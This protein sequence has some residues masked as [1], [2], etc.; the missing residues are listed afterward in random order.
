MLGP[1]DSLE[2]RIERAYGDLEVL[3]MYPSL[4][5]LPLSV[6]NHTTKHKEKTYA[7]SLKYRVSE[8]CD[9]LTRNLFTPDPYLCSPDSL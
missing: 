2:N 1:P 6:S 7:R 9:D 5:P 8:V 3:R 4:D